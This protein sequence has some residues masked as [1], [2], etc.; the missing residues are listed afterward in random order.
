MTR[1][2]R[3]SAPGLQLDLMDL[4]MFRPASPVV[5]FAPEIVRAA[6]HA[7]SISK[8]ISAA[9]KACGRPRAEVAKQMGD[10]LDEEISENMLN[11]YAAEA[12]DEHVIN[13]VRFMALIAITRDRR[14]LEFIAEQNGWAV[15]DR[16]Y[17]KLIE[18]AQLRELREQTESQIAANERQLRRDG[19][20]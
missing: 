11:R 9:L 2:R 14:L 3:L 19:V 20:L 13:V 15:I 18:T 17:L 10:Y 4:L 7:K 1:R 6:S 8:A 5:A 16:R 12:S